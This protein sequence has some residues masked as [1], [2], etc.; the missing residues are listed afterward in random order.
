M[1]KWKERCIGGGM[2]LILLGVL[3]SSLYHSDESEHSEGPRP[4][5]VEAL[6]LTGADSESSERIRSTL[7]R[8]GVDEEQFWTLDREEMSLIFE[9]NRD[10]EVVSREVNNKNATTSTP[11]P[12]DDGFTSNWFTSAC[13][14]DPKDHPD[15]A[16][17]NGNMGR[18]FGP[19]LLVLFSVFLAIFL[20]ADRPELDKL[21]ERIMDGGQTK[22]QPNIQ[23]AVAILTVYD[24][25]QA[26]GHPAWFILMAAATCWAQL[27]LPYHMFMQH[28]RAHPIGLVG[29]KTTEYFSQYWMTTFTA[30][31]SLVVVGVIIIRNVQ[32]ATLDEAIRS[33]RILLYTQEEGGFGKQM[34]QSMIMAGVEQHERWER[35]TLLG[36]T[37]RSPK[38]IFFWTGLSFICTLVSG[39][40]LTMYMMSTIQAA[41]TDFS[42]FV[43]NTMKVVFFLDV[44]ELVVTALDF[45]D[46][47]KNAYKQKI[48]KAG[49]TESAADREIQKLAPKHAKTLNN[50]MTVWFSLLDLMA[51]GGLVI[52][53]L[54]Y[55]VGPDGSLQGI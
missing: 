9:D 46:A 2:P 44:D 31:A 30:I 16:C 48:Q 14:G 6:K 25:K 12:D 22:P 54:T 23:R 49:V 33:H 37:P 47:I 28:R 10:S 27:F 53:L 35:K 39:V 1:G 7:T 15:F 42:T 34:E 51:F 13:K 3:V 41:A 55:W 50:L 19:L 5:W 4:L 36:D 21:E 32:K 18:A 17:I 43:I 11:A 26:N 40:F 52:L 8:A 45:N 20:R 24:I 29:L 38:W